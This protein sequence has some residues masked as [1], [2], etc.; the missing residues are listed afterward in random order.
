MDD[1][2]R[3]TLKLI[4]Y[5]FVIAISIISIITFINIT[6]TALENEQIKNTYVG[7]THILTPTITP[8]P[9][10]STSDYLTIKE[11]LIKGFN[12]REITIFKTIDNIVLGKYDDR[13]VKFKKY[14]M[15][16]LARK[17]KNT[18]EIF[19][20][21]RQMWDCEILFN[22]KISPSTIDSLEYNYQRC[23]ELGQKF[24]FS[25]FYRDF[26]NRKM[27]ITPTARPEL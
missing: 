24:G 20:E 5:S 19:S 14:T 21:T 1:I 17:N 16:F 15:Y 7:P 18:W 23:E 6:R 3:K 25:G 26:Y 13:D 11:D 12:Y 4:I 2:N 10:E 27:K 22:N 8:R 9:T